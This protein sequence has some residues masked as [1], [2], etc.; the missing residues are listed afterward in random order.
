MAKFKAES[1]RLSPRL[2][3]ATLFY[4]HSN[5]PPSLTKL[6][7]LPPNLV[8][9]KPPAQDE[10]IWGEEVSLSKQALNKNK[11]Q[12]YMAPKNVERKGYRTISWDALDENG[13]SLLYSISI[14]REDESKWRLLEPQWVEK[15]LAFDTFLFPDGIYFVKVE[16]SDSPSNPKGTDLKAE[17]I[18]RALVIDNSLPT[19]RNFQ[20]N[21]Q[22]NRLSVSFT[23]EDANSHIKEAKFLVRP[24]DWRVIF[25]EDGIC[26]SKSETFQFS[27]V[28]PSGTDN[29]IIVQVKDGHGN[30]GVH[31]ATF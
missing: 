18:S 31:R 30:I 22:S 23:A 8:F 2:K 26:D 1:S 4:I 16:A 28:L 3:K 6:D 17:R 20:V 7:L 9:L 27:A 13:D 5:V 19:I 10:V 29:L 12:S 14:R 15:I 11:T 21:R 25:P 24:N